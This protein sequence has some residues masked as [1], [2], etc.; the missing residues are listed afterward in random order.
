MPLSD[1]RPEK[2]EVEF[3]GGSFY[4]RGLTLN[5]L[6]E[7]ISQHLN[8]A[9]ILLTRWQ[10][11]GQNQDFLLTAVHDA[12]M[13]CSHALALASDEPEAFQQILKLPAPVALD[14]LQKTLKL[15]FESVGGA[16]NALAIMAAIVRSAQRSTAI[17]ANAAE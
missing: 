11:L 8:V 17:M 3:T 5:D 7:L 10:E 14:G 13:L 9:T 15:T 1:F 12:P 6:S 4:V 16:G 2:A